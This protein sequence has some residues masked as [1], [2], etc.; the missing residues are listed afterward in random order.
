MKRILVPVD[1]SEQSSKALEFAIEEHPDG[2]IVGLHVVDPSEFVASKSIEGGVTDVDLQESHENHAEK[3]LEEAREEAD[4][5]GADIQTDYVVGGVSRSIL[6]FV[7]E[8]DIDH[9]VMGSHG[10]TGTTRV[11]LGSVAETVT[12]RSPVPV[13]IIR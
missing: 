9:V 1:D 12:R 8:N 13:T 10:R 11:L 5:L 6:E 4:S 7:E 2:E 3:L